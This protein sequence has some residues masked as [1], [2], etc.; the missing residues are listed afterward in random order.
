MQL[1]LTQVTGY[2]AYAG[3]IPRDYT[4]TT[5]VRRRASC[6]DYERHQQASKQSSRDHRERIGRPSGA[7]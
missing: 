6:H 3:T 2:D 7:E 4:R 5:V 1:E